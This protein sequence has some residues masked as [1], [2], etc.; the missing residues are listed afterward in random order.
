MKFKWLCVLLGCYSLVKAGKDKVVRK[1]ST[2]VT[3]PFGSKSLSEWSELDKEVLVKSCDVAGLTT[4]GNTRI[5][6]VRL[7]KFY[8]S[9]LLPPGK[10]VCNLKVYVIHHVLAKQLQQVEKHTHVGLQVQV[11]L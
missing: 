7:Y 8:Q 10:R 4:S 11:I 6:A 2:A 9:F 5:L 1:K 3:D